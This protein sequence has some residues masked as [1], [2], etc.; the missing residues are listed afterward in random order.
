MDL[1]D[2]LPREWVRAV[3]DAP[4]L[5][6]EDLDPLDDL[7]I[8][9]HRDDSDLSEDKSLPFQDHRLEIRRSLLVRRDSELS[10]DVFK[11]EDAISVKHRG[12]LSSKYGSSECL[13]SR[14]LSRLKPSEEGVSHELA[15]L[16]IVEIRVDERV[17]GLAVHHLDTSDPG[18]AVGDGGLVVR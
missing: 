11:S 6:R 5:G 18:V 14:H 17:N 3:E 13:G 7:H 16:R 4:T 1:C 12:Y 15:L 2:P 10:L 8:L 9:I